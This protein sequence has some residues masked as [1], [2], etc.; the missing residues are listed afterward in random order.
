VAAK[1]SGS[2]GTIIGVIIGV[3]I[4]LALALVFMRRRRHL[5]EERRKDVGL[6]ASALGLLALR[7]ATAPHISPQRL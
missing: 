1:T 3:I 4:A 6:Q 2:I 5:N 7:R